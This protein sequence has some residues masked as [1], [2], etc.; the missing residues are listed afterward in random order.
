MSGGDVILP[1]MG[2]TADLEKELVKLNEGVAKNPKDVDKLFRLTEVQ[3]ELDRLDKASEF[4]N[5]TIGAYCSAPS[6]TQRG[7]EVAD[8]GLKHWRLIRYSNK[9]TLRINLSDERAKNLSNVLKLLEL[10]M[11][12]MKDES[13]K[14]AV[15]YRIAFIQEN[16]GMLQ[17]ALQ[18]YSD[19]IAAQAMDTGV[20]LTFIIMKAATILKHVG[21]HGQALEYFEF[22]LDEPPKSEGYGRTHILAFLAMTYEHHPKRQ[23]FATTLKKTYEDLLASYTEDLSKGNKPQTNEKMLNKIL[24]EKTIAQ[25]SEIWEM[26]SLQA[27]DRCEHLI[28][29][30]LM[31]QAVEKAPTKHKSLYLLAE[32]SYQLNYVDRATHYAE[33]AFEIQPQNVEL[34]GFL[35]LVAPEKWQ[36]KLRNVATTKVM[37]KG[38]DAGELG[39]GKKVQKAGDGDEGGG[40]EENFFSKMSSGASAAITAIK[41]GGLSP[42]QAEKKAKMQAIREKKRKEKQARKEK[43]EALQKMEEEKVPVKRTPGKPRDPTKDGPARPAKPM[44]TQETIRLLEIAREGKNNIHYYDRLMMNWAHARVDIERAERQMKAQ[45]KNGGKPEGQEEEDEDEE[46]EA[47]T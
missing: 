1:K 24:Q 19:L 40:E 3:I 45:A 44:I 26:I 7:I 37:R 38:G 31:N 15:S 29:F 32:I 18:T 9:E 4:V 25:S 28:A 30:E 8:L 14:N 13:L 20:D 10:V 16:V 23:E 33:R 36:D 2:K 41:T 5:K 46:E 22:L 17:E 12:N 21:N 39:P 11:K 34:R 6:T 43:K 27:I 35:L 42:E 47:D